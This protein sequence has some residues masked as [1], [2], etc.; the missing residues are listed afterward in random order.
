M[1]GGLGTLDLDKPLPAAWQQPHKLAVA[2]TLQTGSDR[3]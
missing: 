2:V 1:N 3:A